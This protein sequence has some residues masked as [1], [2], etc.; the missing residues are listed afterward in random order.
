MFGADLG[1][2]NLHAEQL[3]RRGFKSFKTFLQAR[4][5]RDVSLTKI[6]FLTVLTVFL[7][8]AVSAPILHQSH[9]IGH[10]I[11]RWHAHFEFLMVKMNRVPRTK[12][13]FGAPTRPPN[14][15]RRQSPR[16]E[17]NFHPKHGGCHASAHSSASS[18]ATCMPQS[19][20]KY[21][22]DRLSSDSRPI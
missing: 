20:R 9:R 5:D 12:G 3:R 7:Y 13:S 22:R 18:M 16:R 4:S 21:H 14:R 17:F 10:E 19:R 8:Q 11:L 15:P 6:A 1:R 2:K